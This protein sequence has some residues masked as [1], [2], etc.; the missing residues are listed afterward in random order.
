MAKEKGLNLSLVV[1]K[2]DYHTHFIW[3]IIQKTVVLCI[4]TNFHV[5]HVH[6]FASRVFVSDRFHVCVH[7]SHSYFISRVSIAHWTTWQLVVC[8]IKH[9]IY[10]SFIFFLS[11]NLSTVIEK[12]ETG[13]GSGYSEEFHEYTLILCRLLDKICVWNETNSLELR[14]LA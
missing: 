13:W 7:F 5:F 3:Q 11:T 6:I 10:R 12:W 4:E 9:K 2:E 14:E 8:T 1:F